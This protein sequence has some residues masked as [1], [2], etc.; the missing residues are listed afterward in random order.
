M[1]N[2]EF[3]KVKSLN[4]LYEVSED[5]FVVRNSVSKKCL[6]AVKNN[7]GYWKV[8]V[9]IRGNSKQVYVHR[10]VAE[11]WLGDCPIGYE[12]D[13]IDRNKS[14]NHHSNL[15]Y[16]THSENCQNR[17]T[18]SAHPIEIY[19]EIETLY[20]KSQQDCAAFLSEKY[21]LNISTIRK[22]LTQH[23]H[24]IYGYNIRYLKSCLNGETG[25]HHFME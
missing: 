10:L 18:N 2:R 17:I 20:F 3:R 6:K 4:F 14:N 25:H 8:H 16:V 19:N 13:H 21:N 22:R 15:R 5:G 12:I 23:R 24:H 1:A 11:C 7:C 9:R